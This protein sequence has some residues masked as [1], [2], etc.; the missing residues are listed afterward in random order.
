MNLRKFYLILSSVLAVLLFAFGILILTAS[1]GNITGSRSTS[2]D[3]SNSIFPILDVSPKDSSQIDGPVNILFMVPD[4]TSGNADVIMLFNYDPQTND[5]NVMSIPRDT[6]VKDGIRGSNTKKLNSAYQVGRE[7]GPERTVETVSK[8][9][10]VKIDY[11]VA[12]NIKAVKSIV[13]ALDGVYFEVPRRMKYTDPKQD[14]K[15]DLPKG[16][17]TINGD[18]AEELLRFRKNDDKTVDIGDGERI[19]TQMN[20]IKAMV[21]QKANLKYVGKVPEI[22]N[23]ISKNLKTN[24]SPDL[25]M[26]MSGDMTKLKPEKMNLIQ[27]EGEDKT[28]KENGHNVYFIF[29]NESKTQEAVRKYF[30]K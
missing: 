26:S 24:I 17:Q 27:L 1:K 14:F 5:F 9:L 28:I 29:L 4:N 25:I 30:N 8:L 12:M 18:K 13:D 11:Y 6:Y 7:K 23:A 2:T 16:W 22:L 10:N 20:F 19:K 21:A 3:N 15:I